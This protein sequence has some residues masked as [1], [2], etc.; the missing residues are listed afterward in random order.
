MI[1]EEFEIENDQSSF[2]RKDNLLD[3]GVYG[4]EN[5]N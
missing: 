5:V 2:I 1:E 4:S 3:E